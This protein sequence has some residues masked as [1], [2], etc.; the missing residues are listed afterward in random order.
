MTMPDNATLQEQPKISLENF[1]GKSRN[2]EVD[3]DTWV[4]HHNQLRQ[5]LAESTIDKCHLSLYSI[6]DMFNLI[7]VLPSRSQVMHL[8][9]AVR[10]RMKP[11][12]QVDPFSKTYE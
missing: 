10:T 4:C 9:L 2:V 7:R 12:L 1:A 8:S 6:L 3:E 5:R 11:C